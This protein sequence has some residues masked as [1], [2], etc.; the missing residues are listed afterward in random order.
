MSLWLFDFYRINT[1]NKAT[2]TK[3]RWAET[4]EFSPQELG[5]FTRGKLALVSVL[6]LFLELLMIRWVSSEIQI[7]AYFKNFVLINSCE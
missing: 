2:E 1:R 3:R 7:F 5:G 4:W 6:G